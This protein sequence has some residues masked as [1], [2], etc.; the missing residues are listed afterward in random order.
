MTQWTAT[1]RTTATDRDVD[2]LL[3]H[4]VGQVAGARYAIVL[5]DDGL[6]ISQSKEI[7]RED[8]ERLAAIATGQQSL[9]RGVGEVFG[10]GGVLQIIVELAN[11]WLFISA[12]G[13]GTHLAVLADQEVEAEV[14]AEAMHTLVLQVG[15]HLGTEARIAAEPGGED[16]DDDQPLG[17]RTP[18]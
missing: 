4:L 2:W 6:V 8:A 15:Q 16:A 18:R 14:M 5:S 9:A 13:H 17:R 12:A 3:D 1:P 11:F 7:D 10:G